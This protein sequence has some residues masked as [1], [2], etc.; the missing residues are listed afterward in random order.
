MIQTLQFGP[1]TMRA[2]LPADRPYVIAGPRM[3]AIGMMSGAPP[4]VGAE[5]LIGEMGGLWA[6]PI[7]ALNAWKFDVEIPGAVEAFDSFEGAFWK[8]SRIR[9]AGGLRISETEWVAE[10]EPVLFVEIDVVNVSDEEVVARAAFD[11]APC[12][13]PCWMSPMLDGDDTVTRDTRSIRAADALH[14]GW[15]VAV[16]ADGDLAQTLSLASGE[17]FRLNV[18]VAAVLE[19]GPDAAEGLATLLLHQR[20]AR[21]VRKENAYLDVLD[22]GLATSDRHLRD[23]HLCALLNIK[24]LET[25]NGA[26]RYAMAG[27][28]E[29]PNL[30]GCDIAYS[31]PGLVAAGR[32]DLALSALEALRVVVLRQAGR[33][34]HEVLPDGSTFHPGNTQETPQFVIAAHALW[35]ASSQ[36]I[37]A[38][39]PNLPAA[40]ELADAFYPA[41]RAAILNHLRAGFTW[42]ASAYPDYPHGNAM[43]EREGM[44]ALKLDSVCYTHRALRCLEEMACAW[45]A[46]RPSLQVADDLRRIAAWAGAIEA[47]F[48][49][50]WW[51]EEAGFYADSLGYDGA[52]RLDRHWTQIVPLETG[53]A[54]PGHAARVLDAVEAEWLNADGLPHTK[55]IEERVWTL[56]TGLLALVAARSGRRGLAERLL[57]NIATTL[58]SGQLGLFEE[59]IPSGLCFAQLWSAA[60]FAQILEE[61]NGMK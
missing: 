21:R 11:V 18:A 4:R 17:A 41:C 26:G 45:Q 22:R 30:F 59:L 40:D 47:G 33:V 10:D 39:P 57:L 46:R 32:S 2:A 38:A 34:P 5:H 14:P 29:Y 31:V 16:L 37:G 44:L 19:G 20:E 13:K 7:K 58:Q 28:P 55:D 27:L 49:R 36:K 48:E 3:Y 12:L 8:V 54:S 60:L 23:A 24:L 15:G 51:I 52:Q 50:D 53:L 9:H 6:H 35:R 25:I 56:P 42:P 1:I 43:I 61:V